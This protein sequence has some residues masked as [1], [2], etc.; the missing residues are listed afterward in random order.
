MKYGSSTW[1]LARTEERGLDAFEVKLLRRILGIRWDNFV[2]NENIRMRSRQMLVSIRLKRERLKWFGHVKR[3]DV[4][5]D[6][7]R[8][9][10]TVQIERR[11]LD[12][13]RTRWIDIIVR[14]LEDEN[15][16]LEEAREM[17]MYQPYATVQGQEDKWK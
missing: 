11:P 6:P 13:P 4:N 7:R 12:E 9:L 8:A 1:A 15:Q 16:N 2:R 10:R 3:M 5:R 14:D 17:E